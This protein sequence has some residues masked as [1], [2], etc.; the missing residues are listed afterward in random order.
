MTVGSKPIPI[1]VKRHLLGATLSWSQVA[2]M[3]PEKVNVNF[4]T[5]SSALSATD[6]LLKRYK[7]NQR[8]VMFN[9]LMW[10][11][12]MQMVYETPNNKEKLAH[13]DHHYFD[14]T[15]VIWPIFDSIRGEIDRVFAASNL[16][17]Q[18]VPSDNKN[19]GYYQQTHFVL[20]IIGV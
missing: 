3:T 7:L 19:K 1:N 9:P 11:V 6:L 5:K 12:H 4:K 14:F 2:P 8:Y 13:I 16:E 10:E 15:G 17:H 18:L 20:T